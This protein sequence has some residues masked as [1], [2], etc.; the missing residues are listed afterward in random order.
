MGSAAGPHRQPL[1]LLALLLSLAALAQQWLAVTAQRLAFACG[2]ASYPLANGSCASCPIGYFCPE[3]ANAL[4]CPVGF[5]CPSLGLSSPVLCPAQ[6]YCPSAGSSNGTKCPGVSNTARPAPSIVWSPPG[7]TAASQCFLTND[8]V[9]TTLA[10]GTNGYGCCPYGGYGV[11]GNNTFNASICTDGNGTRVGFNFC[12][13]NGCTPGFA[14]LAVDPR[15]NLIVA[16]THN[17][18][19]RNVSQQG[20][21]PPSALA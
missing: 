21:M 8:T 7:S 14:G 17:N 9:V 10:G 13:G 16:D 6:S 18:C 15:G 1:P 11:S 2:A 20:G 4:V 5:I 12:G 19:I 3:G